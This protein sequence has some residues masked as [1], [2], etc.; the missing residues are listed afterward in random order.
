MHIHVCVT[1]SQCA[2]VCV[3]YTC[4]MNKKI[5]NKCILQ[6]FKIKQL[7]YIKCNTI[8]EKK[9]EYANAWICNIKINF[10]SIPFSLDENKTPITKEF[11]RFLQIFF[12][13]KQL[14]MVKTFLQKIFLQCKHVISFMNFKQFTIFQLK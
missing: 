9:Y 12:L 3:Y 11:F 6:Y 5:L 14:F 4:S 1:A 7:F 8:C 13:Q 10:F 2:S